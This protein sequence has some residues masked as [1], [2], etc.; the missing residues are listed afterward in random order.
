MDFRLHRLPALGAEA[1]LRLGPRDRL[2]VP[3]EQAGGVDRELD[4]SGRR[5]LTCELAFGSSSFTACVRGGAVTMKMTSSTSITSISGTMLISAIGV[6]AFFG[7]KLAKAILRSSGCRRAGRDRPHVRP[8]LCAD[9]GAQRL[10]HRHEG[11]QLV[12][13]G[14]ELGR[15]H[16]VSAR[17]PVCNSPKRTAACAARI[18]PTKNDSY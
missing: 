10:A 6:P 8:R 4:L 14:V 18:A 2:A 12:G 13:E 17:Q 9:A 1:L 7:S 11:M 15:E 3:A 16:A 5:S